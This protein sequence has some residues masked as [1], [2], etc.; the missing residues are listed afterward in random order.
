MEVAKALREISSQSVMLAGAS[1][2]TFVSAPGGTPSKCN[3]AINVVHT[4]A[5]Q[6]T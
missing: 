2:D 3:K 4:K 6:V 1:Q 5:L